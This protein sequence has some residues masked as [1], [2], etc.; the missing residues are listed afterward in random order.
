MLENALNVIIHHDLNL[1]VVW[2][3]IRKCQEMALKAIKRFFYQ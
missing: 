2:F 1:T 3:Q